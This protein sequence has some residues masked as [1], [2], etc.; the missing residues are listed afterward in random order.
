VPIEFPQPPPGLAAEVRAPR[1]PLARLPLRR[2]RARAEAVGAAT[3]LP[4]QPVFTVGLQHLLDADGIERSIA[5]PAHWRITGF[6]AEGRPQVR[7]V[8]EDPAQVGVATGDDR[9]SPLIREALAV[10]AD[11]PRV[12]EATYEARLFRVPAIS[13]LALWLHAVTRN[14]FVVIG[15]P[16]TG[17]EPNRVYD[18]DEF[19][20]ALQ[21][22]AE[23]SLSTYREAER[24]EELGS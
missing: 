22:A 7:E 6:T 9:F 8:A 4:A 11:D 21:A 16:A 2:A 20:V 23:R 10:A 5:G 24:P 14:L 15:R 13:L 17:L 12:S 19:L 3:A 1:R 18:E